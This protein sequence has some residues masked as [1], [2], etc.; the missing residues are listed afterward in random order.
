MYQKSKVSKQRILRITL[1]AAFL[2]TAILAFVFPMTSTVSQ[3]SAESSLFNNSAIASADS[4][5]VEAESITEPFSYTS[6]I[7]DDHMYLAVLPYGDV[8]SET[9]SQITSWKTQGY[10][11][12]NTFF[13]EYQGVKYYNKQT[14]ISAD[15]KTNVE[16]YVATSPALPGNLS[17]M[18]ND[19]TVSFQ[20]TIENINGEKYCFSV[21][22]FADSANYDITLGRNL[23]GTVGTLPEA[24]EKE[25]YHFVGW[26]LDEALTEP[27]VSGM[28]I[29]E[30]TTLYAKYEINTYT[31]NYVINGSSYTSKTVTHGQ[32][33]ENITV[34]EEGKNFV[35]WFTDSAC[36]QSYDF[37]AVTSDITLYAKY[38]VK[39]LTVRFM[40]DGELYKELKVPYGT[41]L[42]GENATASAAAELSHFNVQLLSEKYET[43]LTA[44]VEDVE[45]E[46]EINPAI[47][48]WN[49]F[50]LWLG[51]NWK[52]LLPVLVFSVIVIVFVIVKIK[53]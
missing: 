28:I 13:I 30:D 12:Q 43:V 36:T 23:E 31:V 33:A 20:V 26:Y 45:L 2:L 8:N 44:V 7:G 39:M 32:T 51:G 21:G 25:G 24:P 50:G 37:G 35:G 22:L 14:S 5:V 19:G 53:E 49:D 1:L 41:A 9:I 48:K 52:W 11:P 47:Q 27:F 34:E 17:T 42:I 46:A 10:I 40:V 4:V 6:K 38:E 18:N 15:F 29:T 16:V 3:A